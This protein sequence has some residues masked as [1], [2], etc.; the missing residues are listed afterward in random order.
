VISY[1]IYKL[2]HIVAVLILT[3]SLA[4]F[5][6]G[7]ASKPLKAISG[8]ASLLI[9]AGGMGLLARLGFKHDEDFPYWVWAK[10]GIW[11]VVVVLGPVLAKRIPSHLKVPAFWSLMALVFVAVFLA[12]NKPF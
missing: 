1:P 6:Y 9:L 10:M 2:V 7:Q 4:V 3:A 12:I 11:L 5:F 8:I